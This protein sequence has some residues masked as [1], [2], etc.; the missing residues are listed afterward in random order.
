MLN[1]H[2]LPSSVYFVARTGMIWMRLFS[3]SFEEISSHSHN[4]K[5]YAFHPSGKTD[6]HIAGCRITLSQQDRNEQWQRRNTCG[7]TRIWRPPFLVLPFFFLTDTA[8][9]FPKLDIQAVTTILSKLDLFI[10]GLEYEWTQQ[11]QSVRCKRT[12]FNLIF[13]PDLDF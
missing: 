10:F 1:L 3:T 8:I 11:G 5:W 13:R 12:R 6:S 9:F 4:P 2:I 7:D